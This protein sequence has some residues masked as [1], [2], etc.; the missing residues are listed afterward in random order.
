MK[1]LSILSFIQTKQINLPNILDDKI[2][3]SFD[4]NLCF[5]QNTPKRA[6]T[7]PQTKVQSTQKHGRILNNENTSQHIPNSYKHI[8]LCR[9]NYIYTSDKLHKLYNIFI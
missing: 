7:Q 3:A 4:F 6:E 8:I 1:H 2:N 5:Y 9:K